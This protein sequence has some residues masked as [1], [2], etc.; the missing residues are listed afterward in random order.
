[1]KFILAF[2]FLPLVANAVNLQQF[3]RSHS[4]VFETIEDTRLEK[5][6][7]YHDFDWMFN[8]G[9]SYVDT[10][11]SVKDPNNSKLI[12][13]VIKNMLG[14][15]LGVSWYFKDNLQLGIQSYFS[16]FEDINSKKHAG[17]GDIDLR[18]KWRFYQNKKSAF[19]LMPNIIIPSKGGEIQ[20]LDSVGT[21]FGKDTVLSDG[22]LG[23]G[24]RLIYERY[25]KHF[26]L[27]ANLGILLNSNAIFTPI[28]LQGKYKIDYTKKLQVGLGAYI[29]VKDSWGINLEWMKHFSNPL[30]NKDINPNEVFLGTSIGV[31]QKLIAFAGLSLGNLLDKNDGNKWRAVVGL[32]FTP[33][34]GKT[35]ANSQSTQSETRIINP[36][37]K[38]KKTCSTKYF[39]GNS[40]AFTILYPVNQYKL[41]K[42]QKDS[43]AE[44]MRAITDNLHRI[45]KVT[46]H[47][48]T[49]IRS[50][51]DY[52]FQLGAKR[53]NGVYKYL[54]FHGLPDNNIEFEILSKGENNVVSLGSEDNSHKMNRRVEVLVELK[55]TNTKECIK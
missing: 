9:A 22:G 51:S 44:M 5:S 48:H 28:N 26:Q 4:L 43:L 53:A 40:N 46:I 31:T 14:I 2:F 29:P 45:K 16:Q 17:L 38:T 21:N 19:S 42:S 47:G 49:S 33:R 11:L 10:P 50:D 15:H 25:F 20:L 54:K 39:F 7:V 35:S 36:T 18:V 1:M 37:Q 24:G 52:N 41:N 13:R 3:S 8:I 27:S 34:R 30:F 23:Y 12:D 6:H 55:D 32:K